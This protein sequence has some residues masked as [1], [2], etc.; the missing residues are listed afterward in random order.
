MSA[1]NLIRFCEFDLQMDGSGDTE[2]A[3][4]EAHDFKNAANDP[5]SPNAIGD[6]EMIGTETNVE[7]IETR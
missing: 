6:V 3:V 5:D 7:D 1:G 4:F 2:M